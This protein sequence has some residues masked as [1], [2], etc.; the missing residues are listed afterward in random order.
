LPDKLKTLPPELALLLPCTLH[1]HGGGMNFYPNE[2]VRS[3]LKTE[4]KPPDH[5]P[6]YQTYEA[7]LSILISSEQHK[8]L[9][10]VVA[11]IMR[12]RRDKR[13]RI[14]KNTVFRCLVDFMQTLDVDLE[15]VPDERELLKRMFMARL[16]KVL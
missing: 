7:K 9:E 2:L 16:K 10:D 13:E 6:K 5:I 12:N 14:T 3:R 15:N 1:P 8:Y 11:S 4:K